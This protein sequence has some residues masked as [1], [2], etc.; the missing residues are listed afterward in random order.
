MQG[1]TYLKPAVPFFVFLT[2][3]GLLLAR[4]RRAGRWLAVAG[5]MLLLLWCWQPAA[6]LFAGTLERR[7]PQET[8]PRKN[9]EAIVVLSSGFYAPNPPRPF[10]V[11][12]F[13][14]YLRCRYAAWLYQNGWELPVVVSG[15]RSGGRILAEIMRD[16][17]VKE[18]VPSNRIWLESESQSTMENAQYTARMLHARNIRRIALVT[19]ALHMPRAER[20]FR[21]QGLEVDPSPCCYR[22]AFSGQLSDWLPGAAAMELNDNTFHEWA[23]LL[24]Y[25][26]SGR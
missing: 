2:V 14:T 24:W 18:G 1:W 19:E 6:I 16:T 3:S 5:L 12:G 25:A 17:L 21:G 15:G 13:R 22:G 8:L 26:V 20:V 23:G 7:Y 10:T 11:P 9:V 4:K